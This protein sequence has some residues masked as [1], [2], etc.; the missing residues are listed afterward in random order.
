MLEQNAAVVKALHDARARAASDL[1]T[2]FHR[3]RLE[4]LANIS[5]SR[6]KEVVHKP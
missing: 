5:R 3:E 6:R 2:V 1:D 4:L